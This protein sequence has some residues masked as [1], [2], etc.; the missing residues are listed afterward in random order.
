MKH[1]EVTSMCVVEGGD[2]F[3]VLKRPCVLGEG[4]I[5]RESDSTLH[6]VDC[7][8]SPPQLHILKLDPE[9]GDALYPHTILEI[10]QSSKGEK[11]I[12]REGLRV[13]DLEDSVTVQF[14]RKNKAKSYICAYY[15][16]IAFMDEETGHLSVLKEIIPAS[17]RHIRRFNDGAVD[18]KGRFWAA[19]IDVKGLAYGAG[20]LPAD[21]G[22]P[23]GRLWRYDADGTL[24]QMESGLVCGNGLAWSPDNTKMYLNDSVAQIVYRYDFDAENG[25]LSNKILFIDRRKDGGEPDGMVADRDGNLWIAMFNGSSIM[26]FNPEGKLIKTVKYNSKC[27]ACTTWGGKDNNIIYSVSAYNKFEDTPNDV[28]GHLFKYETETLG[29]KKFEFAG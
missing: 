10:S 27:M 21:H 28:G 13:I 20:K 22:E 23:L 7:L 8:S 5:Y 4:P 11:N 18:C 19:E 1:Q 6:Y 17:E 15:Q 26:V 29:I 24:T 14:F 16:G 25:T 2:P 9:S 12:S 3:Y